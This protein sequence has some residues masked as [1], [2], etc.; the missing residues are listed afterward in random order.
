MNYLPSELI[1]HI[2]GYLNF[3]D[4]KEASLVNKAWYL[5]YLHPSLQRNVVVKCKPPEKGSLPQ[6]LL[7]RRLTHIDFGE[8]R[9]E[10]INEDSLIQILKECPGLMELDLS[11]CNHL[12]F[13]GR[14]L[15]RESDR[16]ILR[17]TLLNLKELKLTGLRQMTDMT[18]LRLVSVCENLERISLASTNIIFGNQ[19]SGLNQISPV[20]FQFSTFLKFVKDIAG[21]IKSIDL[22]YTTVPNDALDALASIKGLVLDEIVLKNCTELSDKGVKFLVTK[23]HSLKILDISEC[24]ELG[25][26]KAFFATLANNLPELHTLL[27]RKCVKMSQCD[28]SSLADFKS[29]TTFDLG[30]VNNLTGNDLVKGLCSKGPKLKSLSLPFCPDIPNDFFIQLSSSNYL[31]T[32]LDLSSC[33]QLSDYALQAILRSMTLLHS[34]KLPYCREISDFGILGYIPEQGVIPAHT[35]DFDHVGCPCIRER[36]SKIFRKPVDIRKEEKACMS[37]VKKSMESGQPLHMLSNLSKLENLDLSSTIRITHVGLSQAIRFKHLRV[38]LL[39]GMARVVDDTLAIIAH[40]NAN[41]EEVNVRGSKITDKGASELAMHCPNL[42]RLDVSQ[43]EGLTNAGLE[44]LAT[45]AKRLRYLDVSYT[46]VTQEGV[47]NIESKFLS[48]KVL[49]RP[50]LY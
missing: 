45:K 17:K 40:H 34:L 13:S 8:G 25:T 5:A 48:L 6:G 27:M 18:F 50:Y 47:K 43:C 19:L 11:G 15:E 42:T 22:S 12:F 41:L 38:L 29:L 49:S 30:E 20:I 10:S 14:F 26:T 9:S 33:H 28:I 39:N 7:R 31:L 24:R 23:Q 36:D 44:L 16:H 4:R 3:N 1:S 35:F 46:S 37:I 2:M 32:Y 21:Q